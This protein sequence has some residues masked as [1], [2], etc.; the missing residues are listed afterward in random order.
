MWARICSTVNQQPLISTPYLIQLTHRLTDTEAQHS[1][2]HR[3]N[4]LEYEKP[5]KE[6]KK[7]KQIEFNDNNPL[8]TYSLNFLSEDDKE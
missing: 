5:M 6:R 7:Q 4:E 3:Q 2:R 1:H 8:H